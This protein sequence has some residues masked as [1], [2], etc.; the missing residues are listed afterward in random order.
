LATRKGGLAAT[1]PQVIG[2]LGQR[3]CP[4]ALCLFKCG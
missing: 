3:V 1:S 2:N 4:A